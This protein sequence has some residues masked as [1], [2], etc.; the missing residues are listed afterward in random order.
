M[1]RKEQILTVVLSLFFVLCSDTT[2]PA[3]TPKEILRRADESR[4][5]LEGVEWKVSI[6]SI[7]GDREQERDMGVKAKGYDFLA[8][9]ASPPKVKGQKILM[10]DHNMWFA[11]P[12][13]RKPVPISPRQKLMG[14]AAYGDIAA[15]NYSDDYEATLFPEEVVTGEHCYVFDLKASTKKATYDRIKYWVSRK[16]LVGVKAQ[17]FTVSDKMFK[18]ATFEYKHTVKVG[19]EQRPFISK[20]IIQDA[21]ILK[22]ITSLQFSEPTLKEVP[23]STFDVNLLMMR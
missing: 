22:N 10:V 2:Y 18:S 21:L 16:R 9:V 23:I 14:G 6:H 12:G 7:E 13:V 8:T 4:G 19:E 20:M 11:K 17:Y 3:M 5:N 1:I 15:T